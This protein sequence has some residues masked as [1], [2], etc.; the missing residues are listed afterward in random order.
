[1]QLSP[2]TVK[3]EGTIGLLSVHLTVSPL[4]RL[5]I[6]LLTPFVIPVFYVVQG[7]S[8]KVCLKHRLQVRVKCVQNFV[9]ETA[10]FKRFCEKVQKRREKFYLKLVTCDC[11]TYI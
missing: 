8:V 1:M 2:L 10:P 11:F 4:V 7:I 6:S 5:S 9:N 3:L